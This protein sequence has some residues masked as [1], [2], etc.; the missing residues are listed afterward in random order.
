V[1]FQNPKKFQFKK[2]SNWKL[3]QKK[4]KLNWKE[5]DSCSNLRFSWTTQQ[6]VSCS[7][8]TMNDA[9]IV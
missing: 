3:L 5:T 7:K 8:I 2:M 4:Q 1:T 9:I 6:N